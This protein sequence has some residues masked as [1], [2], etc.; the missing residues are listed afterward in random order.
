MCLCIQAQT[1]PTISFKNT[2]HNYGVINDDIAE[3]KANFVF[4]NSGNLP[5]V[6]QNVYPSCGCTSAFFTKTPVMPGKK[7]IV[8]AVFHTKNVYGTFHKSIFVYT[9]DTANKIVILYID[10]KIIKKG[11]S[12]EDDFPQSI[13]NLSFKSNHLAFNKIKSNELKTD[14]LWFYNSGNKK[15]RIEILNSYEY[16]S[17]SKTFLKLKPDKKKYVIIT[18]DASKRNDWG[19]NFDKIIIKTNDDTL[20]EKA[21]FVSAEISEDFS[22]LT[23]I[24]LN[25]SP[26]II[27]D[28][29]NYEFGEIK[30]GKSVQHDFLFT[31]KGK[32]DLIVR[33][34]TSSC[35][36][37]MATIDK[38]VLKPGESSK[39][40]SVFN[41]EGKT[42][43]QQKTITLITNDPVNSAIVLSM[44]GF[45]ND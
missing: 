24:Q 45:V 20:A 1:K 14:T 9:N 15:L 32:S 17:I 10:G 29:I 27:F 6:I 18:Y 28:N 4:K 25:N 39:V 35:G 22:K 16:L 13:G 5:L 30:Q 2:I 7:G 12:F 8:E 26:K 19:L 33:K 23:E 34:I 11:K 40:F 31:N 41:T 36:C 37:I 3:V 43:D 42:G 44:I 21:I 38:M